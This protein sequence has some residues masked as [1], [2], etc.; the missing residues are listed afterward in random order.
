[1]EKIGVTLNQDYYMTSPGMVASAI[2]ET[3]EM[4]GSKSF[5]MSI[6]ISTPVDNISP[7]IDTQRLSLFLIQ[8]R[9]FSPVSGTTP[10]FVA[11]TTNVG[12]SAPAKYVTRPVTLENEATALDV[13]LSA[14]VQ[15]TSSV[16]MFYRVTSAEDARKLGNVAWRAFN[17]DGTA[18]SV[19]EPSKDDNDFKEQKFTVSG[20][21]PFSA[22]SLKIVLTG[23]ISSYPPLI[24]DMRGIA[25]AV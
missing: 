13:R 22:F 2:N 8:N 25:L 5:A 11:E 10:D 6:S 14:S 20:L 16:K 1:M 24:K 23:T 17:T 18:D 4:S 7:I 15:S 21:E 12:G 3:N 19:P 9:I